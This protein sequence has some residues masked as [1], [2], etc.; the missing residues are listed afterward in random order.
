MACIQTPFFS[1]RCFLVRCITGS[2][3]L[4]LQLAK[5]W[6][7]YP[8]HFLSLSWRNG[9][10]LYSTVFKWSTNSEGGKASL[11]NMV[12]FFLWRCSDVSKENVVILF[13]MHGN[14]EKEDLC[15]GKYNSC[16]NSFTNLCSLCA[17]FSCIFS[18]VDSR[19]KC[20]LNYNSN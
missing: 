16:S 7:L 20:N 17:L 12:L 18:I 4:Q 19:G 9:G 14:V 6:W 3:K 1:W 8:S 15:S 5:S 10:L 2:L 13:Y 11:I